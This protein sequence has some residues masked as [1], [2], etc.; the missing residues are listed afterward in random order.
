MEI[1]FFNTILID[2]FDLGAIMFIAT[3]SKCLKDINE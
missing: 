1:L 3:I 2:V